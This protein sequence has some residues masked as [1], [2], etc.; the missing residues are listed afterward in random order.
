MH[1]HPMSFLFGAES[2]DKQAGAERESVEEG[3]GGGGVGGGQKKDVRLEN[4]KECRLSHAVEPGCL[5]VSR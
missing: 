5:S 2:Q 1:A 4:S 3:G